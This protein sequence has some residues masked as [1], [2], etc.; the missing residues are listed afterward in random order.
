MK[1]TLKILL[2]ILLFVIAT[3]VG[4]LLGGYK[5]IFYKDGKIDIKLEKPKVE[6][7]LKII[8]LDS[9]TRPVGVMIDNVREALPHA[10]LNDAYLIYEIIV[11]GGYTR[12][13]ALFK[14]TNPAVIG[15]V[16]SL[17]HYFIDYALENDAVIVRFGNSPKALNDVSG[18]KVANLD[19]IINPGNMFWRDSSL[20]KAPHNA[21]TS[22]ENIRKQMTNK[23]YNK[24]VTDT[25]L[26]Y[27]VKKVKLE[28][29]DGNIEANKIK[30]KYSNNHTTYYEYSADDE[31]YLRSM[32]NIP[33]NDRTT[34]NQYKV[35]N[36][37]V[38]KV[39]NYNLIDSEN[40]GRQDLS[41]IG[42]GDGYYITNGK[43]VP[44][45][46]SKTSRSSKTKYTY[47]NGEEIT[48][49]DGNTYIQ[50]MPTSGDL[51]IE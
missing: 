3:S 27:S 49:N 32:N 44:I 1:K 28:K 15:P 47:L 21:F 45:K 34:G 29:Y 16:R 2:V 9:K 14:D 31:M 37:I 43:A 4:A 41:N 18:L 13:F 48:V 26:N 39:R 23:G 33:H 6:E 42:S 35:K 11:E 40:K 5:F 46:Y 30:I 25:L 12:L 38:I 20:T 10:G 19:G 8:D 50:I 36:I 24:D 7:K 17:R 51:T 22:M